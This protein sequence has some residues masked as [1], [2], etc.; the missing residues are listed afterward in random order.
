MS[1]AERSVRGPWAIELVE[2]L[3]RDLLRGKP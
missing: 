1:A 2:S 3:A